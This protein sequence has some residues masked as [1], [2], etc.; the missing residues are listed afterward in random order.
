MH[1]LVS[2]AVTGAV[3]LA[4]EQ[5]LRALAGHQVVSSVTARRL[6]HALMGPVF[7]GCWPL[8]S[9]TPTTQEALLAA[10]VPLL[11]TLK[12]AL[13]GFG[14]LNDDFTVRMLCRHGD[15]TEILYGPV[16][17]GII[18]TTA[19]A[20]YFQ[21]PLAVVCLMNLCVGDVMAAILGAR[22][23]KT[24]WPLPVGNPK[25]ILGSVA[26]LVSSFPASWL[27]LHTM[28]LVLPSMHPLPTTAQLGVVSTAAALVEALSPSKLDNITVFLST[29]FIYHTFITA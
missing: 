20:L 9:A 10:S 5:G 21:S 2:Y 23:G 8:F 1:V 28:G 22:Y 29:L 26:F 17:Y 12:F 24:R 16:Q 13:I 6:T 27:M 3:C 19:T 25:T 18:F 4:L 11:V 15:R 7:M 14:I